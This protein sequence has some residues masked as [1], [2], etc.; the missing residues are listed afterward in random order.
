ML[1]FALATCWRATP[2]SAQ[3]ATNLTAPGL[4]SIGE[5]KPSEVP[6][7][8]DGI[9]LCE[10]I[11]GKCDRHAPGGVAECCLHNTITTT[12]DLEGLPALPKPHYSWPLPA[13]YRSSARGFRNGV[14]AD[15]VR[16]IGTC[17]LD[18]N[19]LESDVLTCVELCQA[20][21]WPDLCIGLNYSP[22]FGSAAHYRDEIATGQY[23]KLLQNITA[24][25]R[26][27]NRRV[28][29]GAAAATRPV[30]ARHVGLGAV[31]LDGETID[32][33]AN[34]FPNSTQQ[35]DYIYGASKQHFPAAAVEWYNR[36]GVQYTEETGWMGPGGSE[37][38]LK[39]NHF[40]LNE[41]GDSF[42]C[43]LYAID[44]LWMMRETVRERWSCFF[45]DC[46][47]L[48]S[49]PLPSHA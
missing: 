45:M 21:T 22:Y 13:E 25:L 4:C 6:M 15:Y 26:A 7:G 14:V 3:C 41:K 16:I 48:A 33:N 35:R 46:L 27:A 1:Q 44:Q 9:A 42:S 19:A 10:R 5:I 2:S 32:C 11:G 18:G 8:I 47:S 38:N 39:W 29:L 30:D 36:G 20:S 37:S 31:M 49:I 28:R 12:N 43:S 17:P 23:P 40:S 34:A 24:W